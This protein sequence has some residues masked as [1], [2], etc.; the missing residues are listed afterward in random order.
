MSLSQCMMVPV[1]LEQRVNS[2]ALIIEG[3]VIAKKSYW[4][5]ERTKIETENTIE[6]YK[7]FKGSPSTMISII[8][9]GGVVGTDMLIVEPSLRLKVG[10]VGVF[11]IT[12]ESGP[13]QLKPYAATQ[14]F[15]EYDE[16]NDNAR[17]VF[18]SYDSYAS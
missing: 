5:S 8:T 15:I 7:V 14:G 2:S 3:R 6:I 4:N 10:D 12:D 9:Q 18:D 16:V 13:D 1:S 11:T 17:S